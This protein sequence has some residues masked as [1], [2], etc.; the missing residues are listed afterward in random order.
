M[1]HSVEMAEISERQEGS[2]KVPATEVRKNVICDPAKYAIS[3]QQA[4]SGVAAVHRRADSRRHLEMLKE[5][6]VGANVFNR[7]PD[8]DTNE[9]PIVRA[10]AAESGSASHFTIKQRAKN[11]EDHRTFGSFRAIFEWA[12]TNTVQSLLAPPQG[13]LQNQPPVESISSHLP[14]RLQY[15][16]LSRPL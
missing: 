3:L 6:I 2:D 7:S 10:R 14:T 15:P 4:G 9:D 5:R 1:A 16:T 11:C 13:P 12:D 8:Y